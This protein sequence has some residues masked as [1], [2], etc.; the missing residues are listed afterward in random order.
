MLNE[1][2]IALIKQGATDQHALLN[3]LKERGYSLTQ[4]SISRKLKQLGITKLH[5]MYQLSQNV[6]VPEA[7]VTFVPPNLIIINCQPGHANVI[8]AILDN[9]LIQNKQHPEFIGSI[10]GDDTI[11]LAVNLMDTVA[12][13]AIGKIKNL[14]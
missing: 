5:G 1:D 13:V 14:L 8:A 7:Q 10:A 4:S 6:F 2:I 9:N 3:K 12:S 11:F